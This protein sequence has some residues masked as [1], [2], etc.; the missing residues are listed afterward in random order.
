M[1]AEC[2]KGGSSSSGGGGGVCVRR[3]LGFRR[4]REE[5]FDYERQ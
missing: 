4:W 1:R 3:R 5:Y 2:S